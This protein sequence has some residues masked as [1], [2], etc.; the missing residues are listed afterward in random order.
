VN[1][2]VLRAL[3]PSRPN[4]KPV[5]KGRAKVAVAVACAHAQ[6]PGSLPKQFR[7]E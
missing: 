6:V 1:S 7:W 4:T 2:T 3:A 5:D